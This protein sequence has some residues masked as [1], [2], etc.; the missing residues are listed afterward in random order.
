MNPENNFYEYVNG[1]WLHRTSI[2]EYE[3]SF[4]VSEEVESVVNEQIKSIVQDATKHTFDG[5]VAKTPNDVLSMIAVSAL[6]PSYQKNNITYLKELLQNYHCLRDSIDC[7][8]AMAEHCLANILSFLEIRISINSEYSDK[9]HL[10]I[11]PDFPG[12]HYN[13]YKPQVDSNKS[14][15]KG[16]ETLCRRVG[17]ALDIQ[18]LES[19]IP[20]E[21]DIVIKYIQAKNEDLK[22]IRGADLEKK[23]PG[24][25]WDT[26]FETLG[27]PSWRK[28]TIFVRSFQWLKFLQTFLKSQPIEVWKLMLKKQIIFHFLRYLPPPFDTY[29]YDFFGHQLQGQTQKTPQQELTISLL[30]NYCQD[31][32]SYLYVKRFVPKSLKEASMK[33]AEEIVAAAKT[34]LATTDW[35]QTTTRKK[36]IEKLDAMRLGVCYPDDWPPFHPLEGLVTDN[37]V[38]NMLIIAKYN[39]K[40]ML[41]DLHT[42]PRYWEE[43]AYRVNAYY[44]SETN[45][46]II[47]AGSIQRPFYSESAPLGWNYG[48]LGA[49]MGHELTHAFDEDGK[50]YDPKGRKKPWW[51]A[52]DLRHYREVSNRLVELYSSQK[53]GSHSV[54]GEYTLSEN[55]ADLGGVAFALDA[56][57]REME[58]KGVTDKAKQLDAY[59]WFFISFAVSWRTKIRPVKLQQMLLL[60]NH[61][62][63]MLRVNCIV[64]QF[65]EWREAFHLNP[66]KEPVIQIF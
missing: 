41:S 6:T 34:R 40:K 43:G 62:P 26:F 15:L 42:K 45:E 4:S 49:I 8:K 30:M 37:L 52:S 2:P 60:D 23:I 21:N 22:H 32:L 58:K 38:K 50:E 53:F 31:E 29:H 9:F 46:F 39:F 7:C 13:Y 12:I 35:L 3:T 16:Y 17:D 61:S 11:E 56:L 28:Q 5:P 33:L 25:A 47:P 55:I 59:R 64:K 51:T 65:S 10:C 57:K 54:N 18:G 48:G 27:L 1:S 44:Y 36:A 19:I 63:P 66:S 14:V 20:I 24:F